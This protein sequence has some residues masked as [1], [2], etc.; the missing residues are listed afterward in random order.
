MQ[1]SYLYNEMN[2]LMDLFNLG[3]IIFESE[4]V[5]GGQS[6]KVYKVTTTKGKYAVKVL[7]PLIITHPTELKKIVSSEKIAKALSE[8][9]PAVVAIQKNGD[10]VVN[11]GNQYYL[12]FKW[13]MGRTLQPDQITVENCK[14]IGNILGRIHTAK[15]VLSDIEKTG[16]YPGDKDKSEKQKNDVVSDEENKCF[17]GKNAESEYDGVNEEDESENVYNW[18]YYLYKGKADN[19]P[20]VENVEKEIVDL[21]EWNIMGNEADNVLSSNM[22]LSHRELYPINVL[23]DN[24]RPFIIDWEIAGYIN[25]YQELM[26]VLI[27]WA[28]DGSG[29]IIK[30]KFMALLNEYKTV[31]NMPSIEWLP[32][33]YSILSSR[34]GWLNYNFKRSLKIES[35]F[36]DEKKIGIEQVNETLKKLRQYAGQIEEL[37]SWLEE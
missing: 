10:S 11:M 35:S 7:N 25:P 14:I 17:S 34:L 2:N 3:E 18:Y 29:Q 33:L 15:I 20:W 8:I 28:D 36:E 4:T 22:V 27:N 16:K 37:Q 12:V 26:E 23:W 9:V 1:K 30:D 5:L 24:D 13:I 21:Y 32:V 31:T 6:H 19:L